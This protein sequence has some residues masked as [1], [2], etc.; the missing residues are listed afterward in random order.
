M[1]MTYGSKQVGVEIAIDPTGLNSHGR[2]FILRPAL[3]SDQAIY[4]AID[5]LKSEIEG[6]G[7]EA[8]QKLRGAND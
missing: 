7:S 1:T 2:A 8:K 6:L 5:D 4:A 3:A